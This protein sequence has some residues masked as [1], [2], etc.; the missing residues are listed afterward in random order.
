MVGGD[1]TYCS[2]YQKK[3]VN[4]EYRTSLTAVH[5]LQFI[6]LNVEFF[7]EDIFFIFLV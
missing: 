6:N 7:A 4:G 2:C 3:N 5:L 1:V